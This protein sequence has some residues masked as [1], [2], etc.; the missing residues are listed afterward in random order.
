MQLSDDELL[1]AV[2]R[3][4]ARG[5]QVTVELIALLAEID[6]R[7]LYLGEGCGSLFAYC[8]ERLRLSEQEAYHRIAAA[9]AARSF[10]VI[11][12]RLAD[13]RV[14]L[15]AVA[16]LRTHLTPDNHLRLLDWA[17]RRGKREVE[18]FVRGL[19]PLPDVQPSI[20]KL[21]ASRSVPADPRKLAASRSVPA[22]PI[23]A[24]D[25]QW[26]PGI[27]P[28]EGEK[29]GRKEQPGADGAL[30]MI[31]PAA[32]RVPATGPADAIPTAY[33]SADASARHASP[34]AGWAS[35]QPR[36]LPCAP[37][38]PA[39]IRP[40]APARYSLHVTISEETHGKLR[41]AQDLLRHAIPNADP[42]VVVDR[43]LTLLVEHLERAK[44]GAQKARPATRRM[45]E[46]SDRG[47]PAD[48]RAEAAKKVPTS[49]S[50]TA[51]SSGPPPQSDP[52]RQKSRGSTR[53]RYIPASVRRAV[54]HR[55]EGRCAFT[56]T[57]GRC[58]ETGRLEF[59]HRVP[60]AD[61]GRATAENIE[62]RCRSHND[63]EARRWCGAD[64]GRPSATSLTGRV[65]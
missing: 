54:W 3:I 35:Q 5:R 22:D 18:R 55:D 26:E 12:E 10:P 6:A 40:L 15:T 39:R 29:A 25:C 56:G 58:A 52:A 59:H 50:A 64:A 20:R 57:G 1:S 7:R 38:V 41:K 9:R 4:A 8:V 33:A 14:T 49:D 48:P 36:T 21:A 17:A 53:S 28:L 46:R 24:D 31:E 47:R 62:L 43:A 61:G 13:G 44:F 63:W 19:V 65:G 34:S 37:P 11:L 16:L 23:A 2:A 32:S 60:F 45:A 27:I 51:P 30:F 42:A